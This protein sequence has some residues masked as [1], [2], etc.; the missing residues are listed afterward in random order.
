MTIPLN[1]GITVV[2]IFRDS[3][4]TL[5][6]LFDSLAPLNLPVIAVDT[7]SMDESAEICK[8]YGADLYAFSWIDDFSA[9]K[10]FAM[11][12]VQTEWTF[13]LD[14]DEWLDEDS[15]PHLIRA[16][17]NRGAFA[18]QVLRREVQPD[19]RWTAMRLV[20]LWR[21]NP[22]MK[23]AGRVHEHF[24]ESTLK[25]VGQGMLPLPSNI[26]IGHDGL[27]YGGDLSKIDRNL[28][29][30]ELELR[31]RPGQLYY[32]LCLVESLLL[33][34]RPGA[35]A[36]ARDLID[37]ILNSDNGQL[38][39]ECSMMFSNLLEFIARDDITDPRIDAL[40]EF[41]HKRLFRYPP[42][43]WSAAAVNVER[44]HYHGAYHE[45]CELRYMSESDQY[46]RLN[47][48]H[49][50]ILQEFLWGALADVSSALGKKED[51]EISM[52]RLKEIC[53]DDKRLSAATLE[54]FE[55]S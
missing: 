27:S 35:T 32:E 49:P 37:R 30:I 50:G 19:R 40:I 9:A 29:Y 53:P 16:T 28:R 26:S 43:L 39:D 14:S 46:D 18:Y 15:Y 45:L 17:A 48:F 6:R 11:D 36:I 42:A 47:A 44:G 21:T 51:Y 38:S 31:D 22:A 10:N 12:L 25:L 13:C 34:S 20:R 4:M 41:I 7:G 52:A 55:T 24:P 23:L 5:P 54:V 8:E 3:A 2:T 1:S 33:L